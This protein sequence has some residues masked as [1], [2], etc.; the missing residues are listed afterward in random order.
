MTQMN[1][2]AEKFATFFKY[3]SVGPNSVKKCACG[4]KITDDIH[5][6]HVTQK[7]SN[8]LFNLN[9]S[10]EIYSL[11]FLRDEKGF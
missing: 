1:A 5:F 8:S 11:T 2:N 9:A 7:G 4:P 10:K 6:R 3:Q